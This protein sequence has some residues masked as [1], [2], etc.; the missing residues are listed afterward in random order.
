MSDQGPGPSTPD[1]PQDNNRW[2]KDKYAQFDP[3]SAMSSIMAGVLMWGLIGYGFSRWL[4]IKA[5]AGL[6]ILIGGVLGILSVY[7][8][9]G[10]PQ[11]EPPRKKDAGS[12]PAER[13]H[14]PTATPP[15][16]AQEEKP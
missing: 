2:G 16:P 10:R 1:R 12:T 13:G 5:L 7:L 14:R 3:W 9:Y 15:S 11:P 6:G 8:R 4:D